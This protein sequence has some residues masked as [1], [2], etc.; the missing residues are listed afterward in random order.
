MAEKIRQTEAWNAKA[1]KIHEDNSKLFAEKE[2]LGKRFAEQQQFLEEQER[3]QKVYIKE[4]E[5]KVEKIWNE[6]VSVGKDW[7]NKVAMI[8]ELE[9]R[10]AQ[11]ESK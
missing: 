6:L 8:A 9:S 1:Q 7:E 2:L 5:E 3:A 10:L 11:K 4:L